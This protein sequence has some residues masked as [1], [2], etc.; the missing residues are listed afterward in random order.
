MNNFS[1]KARTAVIIISL[2]AL[3]MSLMGCGGN[4]ADADAAEQDALAAQ[5]VTK[6]SAKTTTT[7]PVTSSKITSK[8][9]T[10]TKKV[11]PKLTDVTFTLAPAKD[12]DFVEYTTPIYL[13][14]S[15]TLHLN[16]MVIKGG[17]HFYLTFTLPNGK[18]IA[19]C[20]DGSLSGY[21][22]GTMSEKLFSNGSVVFYPADNNWGDGY[23]IFHPGIYQDDE[24]ITVKL[25]YYVE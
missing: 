12:Q 14:A 5:I 11:T 22:P 9:T 4:E 21:T 8:T 19:V 23:Y 7:K 10:T 17:D 3:F 15:Q 25:M 20:N 2:L 1:N 24:A 6:T 18:F 13:L 16:W